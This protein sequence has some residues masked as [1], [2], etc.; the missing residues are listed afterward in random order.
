MVCLDI[1]SYTL[2][3]LFKLFGIK[4]NFIT[5]EDL[6]KAKKK[7]LQ[8]HPDK[9]KY[10]HKYFIFYKIAYDNIVELYHHQ[11][12]ITSNVNTDNQYKIDEDF[13]LPMVNNICNN[14]QFQT[15]FNNVYID[16]N[17]NTNEWFQDENDGENHELKDMEVNNSMELNT[18]IEKYKNNR[19]SI[20]STYICDDN[21]YNN[22]CYSD[23]RKVY[24]D[25]TLLNSFDNSKRCNTI[26]TMQ[27]N[28][29]FQD[30]SIIYNKIKFFD[31]NNMKMLNESWTSKLRILKNKEIYK[32][33]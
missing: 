10:H 1:S 2:E 20:E 15:L 16:Q 27:K 31:N 13:I 29:D 5:Y 14:D 30:R 22:S 11:E 7:V 28:R 24:K 4:G 18:I 33:K 12:K 8:L 6:V 32:I 3:E 19:Q 17:I 26:E 23:L 9:S 21:L 25:Q